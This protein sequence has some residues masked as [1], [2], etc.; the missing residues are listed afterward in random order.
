MAKLLDAIRKAINTGEES[1][2]SVAKRAGVARSQISRL[3][4][5][6]RGVSVDV[7]ERLAEALGLQI[8]IG[9]KGRKGR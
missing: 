9:R 1:P 8:T 6:E 3:L 5:G 4:S 7:A 2:A